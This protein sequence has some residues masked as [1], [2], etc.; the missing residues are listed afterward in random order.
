ML[1]LDSAAVKGGL[2]RSD[3]AH[4]GPFPPLEPRLSEL[5]TIYLTSQ[6]LLPSPRKDVDMPTSNAVLGLKQLIY[7]EQAWHIA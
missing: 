2:L 4:P 7:R 5:L 6:T 1:R 3:A